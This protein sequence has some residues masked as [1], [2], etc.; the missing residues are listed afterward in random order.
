MIIR[1]VSEESELNE[2]LDHND[3]VVVDFWAEWCRPCQGF[4]P[5]LAE[6]ADRHP[7]VCFCRVNA[8]KVKELTQAF[9]VESIPTLVV[10]R[11]RV[12][13]ASQPGLLPKD[14]LEDLIQKV[15]TLDMVQVRRELDT[16]GQT[17]P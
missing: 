10:I 17:K 6:A 11:D 15:K 13:I 4:L 16:Q 1:S 9:E 2:V 7:D 3:T 12:M 14:V 8:G 5:I